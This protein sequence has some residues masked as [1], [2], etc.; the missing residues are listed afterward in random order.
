MRQHG[1]VT[2]CY[3]NNNNNNNSTTKQI[4]FRTSYYKEKHNNEIVKEIVNEI[5][6]D[7]EL[8]KRFNH[9]NSFYI[10]L[11]Y[12]AFKFCQPTNVSPAVSLQSVSCSVRYCVFLHFFLIFSGH[13]PPTFD[14]CRTG[15]GGVFETATRSLQ[16]VSVLQISTYIIMFYH[17]QY[18]YPTC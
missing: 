18:L 3:N 11:L 6:E 5:I 10:N 16:T 12:R 7:G 14:T 4:K 8:S 1:Y 15:V 13:L 2:S 9:F 17:I